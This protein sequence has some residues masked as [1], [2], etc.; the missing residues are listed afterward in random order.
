MLGHSR[1]DVTQIYAEVDREKGA[2]SD[3]RRSGQMQK[4]HP[5]G[6]SAR[7]GTYRLLGRLRQVD[8]R[9]K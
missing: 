4:I 9:P 6:K 3:T 7:L 2:V 8:I 5:S 1:M